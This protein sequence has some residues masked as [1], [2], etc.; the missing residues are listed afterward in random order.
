MRCIC[1]GLEIIKEIVI[2]GILLLLLWSY[3]LLVH[4]CRLRLRSLI[5]LVMHLWSDLRLSHLSS[6]LLLLPHWRWLLIN[7]CLRRHSLLLLLGL[8]E[9]VLK[10][11]LIQ[12]EIV[13]IGGCCSRLHLGLRSWLLVR[14][15]LLGLWLRLGHWL[16]LLQLH[17]LSLRW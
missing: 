16:W 5:L 1:C 4:H 14:V 11:D 10:A 7:M 8:R 17:R 9:R 2:C 6:W 3:L 12:S 13:S 15:Q